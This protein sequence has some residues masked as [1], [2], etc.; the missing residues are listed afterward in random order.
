MAE[1]CKYTT[2]DGEKYVASNHSQ[3][4][5][6]F[7]ASSISFNGV[8]FKAVWETEGLKIPMVVNNGDGNKPYYLRIPRDEVIKMFTDILDQLSHKQEIKIQETSN[9]NGNLIIGK[10]FVSYEYL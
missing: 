4:I 9:Y 8:E 2:T 10:G 6:V 3:S 1:E 5:D 7:T